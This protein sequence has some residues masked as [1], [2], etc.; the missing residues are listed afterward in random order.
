MSGDGW[1]LVLHGPAGKTIDKLKD[2]ICF[3]G[4]G[5]PEQDT[6]ENLMG[7]LSLS[8]CNRYLTIRTY[9]ADWVVDLETCAIRVL[10]E[11]FKTGSAWV[12]DPEDGD[13]PALSAF[14]LS[15]VL[16][17]W[18]CLSLILLVGIVLVAKLIVAILHP[19]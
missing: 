16:R 15:S 11:R 8:K 18:G 1:G 4:P 14:A 12:D 3:C 9:D 19:T 17:R 13:P 6:D 5:G 10:F 7:R 2:F